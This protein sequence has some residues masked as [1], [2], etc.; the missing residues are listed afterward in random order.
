MGADLA[1]LRTLLAEHQ[2]EHLLAHWDA[3]TP[4]EQVR[5]SEELSAVDFDEVANLFQSEAAETD[6][7]EVAKAARGPKA[8]R[9]SDAEGAT[10]GDKARE[11][12]RKAL[13]AGEVAVLIVAGGQGTRLGFDHPKGMFPIAPESGRT[14][15]QIH[16]E[17]LLAQAKAHSTTIPLYLMTSPATHE[18]TI[19]FLEQHNRFGLPQKDLEVFCQGTM[20]AVDSKSGKLLLADKGHLALSPDGHGGVV[21]ALKKNGLLA[22][23]QRRGI[24]HLFYMQVDNPLVSVADPEFIG[25]HLEHRSQMSTQVVRKQDALEKVGNVVS[26]GERLQII[27]YSDLPEEV[28]QRADDSGELIFWAGN[29]AVHVI[30]V[31]FLSQQAESQAALPWH[32]A[33]KQVPHLDAAGT[34]VEPSQPNALKFERFIFDLLPEAAEAIVVEVP[35]GSAFAPVKSAEDVELARRQLREHEPQWL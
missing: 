1:Q 34:M 9:L 21:E 33:R 13:A 28:G 22:D 20:P 24:R 23:M 15:F 35:R 17:K 27:E 3:L 11:R 5:F 29:I 10:T 12:G 32:I 18:E 26:V 25:H 16:I 14:L 6:W 2:Q 4:A 8:V 30:D 19:G 7:L 31:D